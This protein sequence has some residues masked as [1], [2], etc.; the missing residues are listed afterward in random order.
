VY[1]RLLRRHLE[2]AEAELDALL[3][4]VQHMH[5]KT[6]IDCSETNDAELERLSAA[7]DG[8]LAL[9]RLVMKEYFLE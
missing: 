2:T 5:G 7:L 9:T 3:R 8:M 4:S 6:W 1:N